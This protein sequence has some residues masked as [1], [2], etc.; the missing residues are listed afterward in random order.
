VKTDDRSETKHV[1]GFSGTASLESVAGSYCVQITAP[2]KT[3]KQ[4]RGHI[5]EKMIDA[6]VLYLSTMYNRQSEL[7]AE[8]SDDGKNS[9]NFELKFE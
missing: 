9:F 6:I 7:N 4:V 8:V 3:G 5:T 2:C 1:V